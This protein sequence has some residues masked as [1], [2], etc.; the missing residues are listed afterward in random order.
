V[1]AWQGEKK[2]SDD[3]CRGV[4]PRS[5]YVRGDQ[6]RVGTYLETLRAT[7]AIVDDT[8]EGP[9]VERYTV[10]LEQLITLVLRLRVGVGSGLGG[11][12]DE[13]RR[14]LGEVDLGIHIGSFGID[15]RLVLAWSLDNVAL[16]MLVG[17]IDHA[18]FRSWVFVGEERN[19][20]SLGHSRSSVLEFLRGGLDSLFVGL[21]ILLGVSV[22]FGRI[23]FA[24]LV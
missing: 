6:R 15:D 1:R 2:S 14:V 16:G 9:A 10:T 20:S 13:S 12:L 22:L 3:G 23:L 18:C 21:D 7:V 19:D 11:V 5:Q 24:G 17:S 8:I 4:L